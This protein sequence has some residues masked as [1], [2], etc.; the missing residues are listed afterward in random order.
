MLER[1]DDSN[2]IR[3]IYGCGGTISCTRSVDV[4][5]IDYCD[6]D[7]DLIDRHT[8]ESE[9]LNYLNEG[10]DFAKTERILNIVDSLKLSKSELL[11]LQVG[12]RDRICEVSR[13]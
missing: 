5:F 6:S 11:K 4:F 1:F 8:V 13:K 3:N 9:F 10:V 2:E 7:S 12:L